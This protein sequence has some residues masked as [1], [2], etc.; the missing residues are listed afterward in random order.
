MSPLVWVERLD[1]QAAKAKSRA[2]SSGC[3]FMGND[4]AISFIFNR[5]KVKNSVSG[6]EKNRIKL[7]LIMAPASVGLL[8]VHLI[9]SDIPPVALVL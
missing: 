2:G 5:P 6:D 7:G 1:W 9:L 4:V 8:S 3:I